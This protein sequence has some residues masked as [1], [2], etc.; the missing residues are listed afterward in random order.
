[1]LKRNL[2]VMKLKKVIFPLKILKMQEINMEKSLQMLKKI[3]ASQVDFKNQ[4]P[5]L[6]EIIEAKGHRVFHWNM[7]DC[8]V[9][10][11]FDCIFVMKVIKKSLKI[12]PEFDTCGAVTWWLIMLRTVQKF[13]CL[14]GCFIFDFLKFTNKTYKIDIVDSFDF[15][16]Y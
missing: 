3:L 8:H 15:V 16:T 9:I 5:L 2:Q 6:Q 1:M 11:F 12:F 13:F 14:L 4:K 7:Q 10:C